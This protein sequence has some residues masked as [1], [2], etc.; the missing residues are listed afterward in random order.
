[1]K[2]GIGHAGDPH[3]MGMTGDRAPIHKV[4]KKGAPERR[5]VKRHAWRSLGAAHEGRAQEGLRYL[6]PCLCHVPGRGR[7]QQFGDNEKAGW[8]HLLACADDFRFWPSP[9]RKY[10]TCFRN[11]AQSVRSGDSGSGEA[12][13]EEQLAQRSGPIGEGGACHRSAKARTRFWALKRHMCVR[14][15]STHVLLQ[16]LLLLREHLPGIC[17]GR[18]SVQGRPPSHARHRLTMHGGGTWLE[19]RRRTRRVFQSDLASA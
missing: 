9:I 3:W 17:A 15:L 5:V 4:C 10:Y 6:R 1:M 12:L 11:Y 13:S 18:S 19:W 2:A 16:T 7:L 14:T 8:V